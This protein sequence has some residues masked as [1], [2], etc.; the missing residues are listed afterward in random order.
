M[1]ILFDQGTP[2]P[3]RH[4]LTSHVVSTAYEENWST[5]ANG[6]LIRVAEAAGFD[7]LVT[8]DQNLKYQQN[9]AGRKIGIA[10]ILSASW[11]KLLPR[12]EQ[13]AATIG[14]VKAGQYVEVPV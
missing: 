9:L 14:A 3:L 7:C 5:L 1:K 4:H 10:V 8:T 12:V 13:I 11:P 2:V 6:E